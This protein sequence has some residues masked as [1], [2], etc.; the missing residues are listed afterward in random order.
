MA[1]IVF[2]LMLGLGAT[3]SIVRLKA[4]LRQPWFL[5][6]GFV[7]QYLFMPFCSWMLG[8]MFLTSLGNAGALGLLLVGCMPGGTTSNLYCLYGRG[9]VGMSIVMT[10]CSTAAAFFMVPLTVAIYSPSFTTAEISINYAAIFQSLLLVLIPATIGMATRN[11]DIVTVRKHCG[12]PEQKAAIGLPSSG[13]EANGAPAV[14]LGSIEGGDVPSETPDVKDDA[15]EDAKHGEAQADALAAPMAASTDSST[16]AS[17]DAAVENAD[18]V[19]EEGDD[20]PKRAKK[21]LHEK[22][23][24]VFEWLAAKAGIVFILGALV[25]GGIKYRGLLRSRYGGAWFASACLVPL[26]LLF[27]FLF[28]KLSLCRLRRR[29]PCELVAA[30]EASEACKYLKTIM[31]ETGFQNSTLAL[32]II[33]TSWPEGDLREELIV[34]PLLYSFLLN[35]EGVIAV[36]LMRRFV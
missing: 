20:L 16:V 26:G 10:V 15:A 23:A 1:F 24:D 35:V 6:A 36:L 29:R 28:G 8:K 32:A 11:W 2:V 17:G 5:L 7:S 27:G 25:F 33:T 12:T 18:I 30:S 19:L 13:Y 34:T 22:L 21:P 14:A 9:D 31:L 4:K 3:V